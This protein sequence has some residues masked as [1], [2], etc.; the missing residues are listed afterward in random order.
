MITKLITLNKLK[1]LKYKHLVHIKT[2]NSNK[3]NW[4]FEK[5]PSCARLKKSEVKHFMRNE[6]K[7]FFPN[8]WQK[9]SEYIPSTTFLEFTDENTLINTFREHID[10]G[11]P[12]GEKFIYQ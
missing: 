5:L 8:I 3:Y 9:R 4:D 2:I 6:N 10:W 1:L 11:L 12:K 7:T